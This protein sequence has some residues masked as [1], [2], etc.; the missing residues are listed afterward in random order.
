MGRNE[1]IVEELQRGHDTGHYMEDLWKDNQG[2]LYT[3][4]RRYAGICDIEDLMQEAY[5][6][7]HKAVYSYDP[8]KGV[9]FST[10][11]TTCAGNHLKRYVMSNNMIKMPEAM[12]A[13]IIKYNSL[14]TMYEMKYGRR[15]SEAEIGWY[16]GLNAQQVDKLLKTAE[17]GQ[18]TSLQA[19]IGGWAEGGELAD[20]IKDP[21]QGES[22]EAVLDEQ[23]YDELWKSVDELEPEQAAVIYCIYRDG[24]NCKAAGEQLRM[25]TRTVNKTHHKALQELRRCNIDY[26]EKYGSRLY[27]KG[28]EW[29]STPERIAVYG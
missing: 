28:S 26:R 5:I 22:L 16:L 6:A 7:M 23:I 20:M 12:V 8:E 14:C 3:A 18:I 4:T 15:P 1:E 13:K 11:L 17:M 25:D 9:Q 2:L 29:M 19:P 21:A 24:M 10:Y 27:A